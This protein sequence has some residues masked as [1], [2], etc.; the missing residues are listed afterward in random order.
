MEYAGGDVSD[1]DEEVV[2]CRW[3]PLDEAIGLLKYEDE[4]GI[5]KKA[6]SVLAELK[7]R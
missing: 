1:H 3:F 7:A 5:L 2:D 4:K 6:R